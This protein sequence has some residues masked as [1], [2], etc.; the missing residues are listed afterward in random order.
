MRLTSG[1]R[2]LIHELMALH[3]HLI[4]HGELDRL[5]EVFTADVVYDLRDFAL[6]ELHGIDAITRASLE[7]GDA[8]PLGHHVTNVVVADVRDDGVRVLSKGIGIRRDGSCGTV[9]YDDIV[10]RT[11]DGW[12]IA[13]R[14]V[15]ARRAPLR[16]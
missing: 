10:R 8:N 14:T 4:D 11:P 9:V 16:R 1:D 7:L 15:V 3:G 2:L 12:R 6:G 13:R 5:D